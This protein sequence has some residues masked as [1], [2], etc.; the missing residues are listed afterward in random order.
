MMLS[1]DFFVEKIISIFSKNRK[2]IF[3]QLCLLEKGKFF[4]ITYQC[5]NKFVKILGIRIKI[6]VFDLDFGFTH[7][8]I[9]KI[10]SCCIAFYKYNIYL[11]LRLTLCAIGM[12]SIHVS[13]TFYSMRD[14]LQILKLFFKDDED[15]SIE[16]LLC[17]NVLIERILLKYFI[18]ENINIFI[19]C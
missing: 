3:I 9:S 15:I 19:P 4:H 12:F 2:I 14:F 16:S 13:K 8:C 6:L 7:Q 11:S 17:K 10:V 1:F 18:T 5:I